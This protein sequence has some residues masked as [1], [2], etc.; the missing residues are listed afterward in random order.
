MSEMKIVRG[1]DVAM[2]REG[3]IG[4]ERRA[5][6]CFHYCVACRTGHDWSHRREA[7]ENCARPY[8]EACKE[9]TDAAA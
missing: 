7:D 5:T 6:Y 3:S 9:A 8:Y 4:A 1:A 2:F